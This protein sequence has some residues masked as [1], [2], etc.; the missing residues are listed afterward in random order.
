M[1][2]VKHFIVFPLCK[3]FSVNYRREHLSQE[4][5]EKNKVMMANLSKG[6]WD[7]KEVSL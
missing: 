1:I 4:D 3:F 6:S 7:N 5:V 2:F